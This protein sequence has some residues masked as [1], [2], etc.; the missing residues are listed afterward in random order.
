MRKSED[1]TIGMVEKNTWRLVLLA[2]VVILYL[3]LSLLGLQFLGF[4]GEESVLVLQRNA[5]KLSIFLSILIFLFCAYV[6]V[7]Q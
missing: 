6:I 4:L 5:Y 2:V 1:V 3:T 7:Q